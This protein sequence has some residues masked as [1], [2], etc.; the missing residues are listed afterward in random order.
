MKLSS[1]SF[2]HR[3]PIPPEFAFGRRGDATNPIA[4]SDN[5]NPHLAWEDAPAGTASFV[6]WCVDPD[7]P[8]R[9]DDVNQAGRIIPAEL[10]RVEFSHW[11]MVDIPVGV[12]EIAEGALSHGITARGK[13]A[14]PGPGGARQGVN[15]YTGWFANDAEMA[16][17]YHG[18]DGPCPPFNDAIAHRYFFRLFALDVAKLELPEGFTAAQAL[19]A[20]QGHVLDEVAI[21]GSYGL[22]PALD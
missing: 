21:Y 7:V 6:L 11:I 18:Y 15:D 16:G 12:H 13:P 17:S 8:S 4:L 9:G 10:P 14:Q 19:A 2:P 3:G 22:N 5:R 20:M 1:R